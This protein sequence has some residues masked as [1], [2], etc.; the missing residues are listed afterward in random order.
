MQTP[1]PGAPAATP[2]FELRAARHRARRVALSAVCALWVACAPGAGDTFSSGPAERP[3]SRIAFGSC[4][5]QDLPQPIWNHVL[6]ARPDVFVFLGDNV[7]ADTTDRDALRAAYAKLAAN[8]GFQKLR[9]A[10][11]VLAVWDDHDYGT[12]DSGAEHPARAESQQVFLDFWGAPPDDPRRQ[13][14][15][16]YHAETFGPPGRRVQIILLDTRYFRSPITWADGPDGGHYLPNTDPDAT[17]LGAAQWQWLEEQLR[18]PAN[19]RIVASSIQV[20]AE[21]ASGEKWANFPLER[22]RLFELIWNSRVTGLFF[23]SGDMHYA[24]LS[25]MDG[26]VGFPLY[27]LTSSSLNWSERHWRAYGPNRHRV[28]TMNWGDNFGLVVIDWEH[29]DPRIRFQIVDDE[30]DINIQRKITLQVL[31]DGTIPWQ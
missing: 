9:S 19:V 23:I 25:M 1:R 12:D 7:Y 10:T 18:V 26:G 20:V 27:D 29:P 15:G 21:D 17:L 3:I 28:G 30:G 8:A 6:E 2:R 31:R 22:K 5:G 13:R 4:I 11:R 14:E 16:I 24:E